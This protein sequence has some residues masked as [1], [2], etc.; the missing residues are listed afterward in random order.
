MRL[1]P[2]GRPARRGFSR[3]NRRLPKLAWSLK[4]NNPMRSGASW[5]PPGFSTTTIP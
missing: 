2:A 4:N 1:N 3:R 5:Q